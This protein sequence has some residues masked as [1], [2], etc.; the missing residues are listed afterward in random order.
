M[1]VKI[2]I[3]SFNTSAYFSVIFLGHWKTRISGKI[4]IIDNEVQVYRIVSIII[5]HSCHSR[6]MGIV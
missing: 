3:R 4:S 2:V 5:K 6:Q 1:T